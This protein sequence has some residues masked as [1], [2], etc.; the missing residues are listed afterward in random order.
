MVSP[1][2]A[3]AWR[4]DNSFYRRRISQTSSP[5]VGYIISFIG[6]KEVVNGN[7]EM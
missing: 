6:F 4:P 2:R 5:P 7:N 1:L 3:V